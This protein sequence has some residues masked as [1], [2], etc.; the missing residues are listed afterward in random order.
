MTNEYL[1]FAT[2]ASANVLTQSDYAALPA[3]TSGF[4]AGV[5]KSPELNKVWRQS[6]FMASMLAQFI[7]DSSG[8]D[9]LDDGNLPGL[10][11]KLRRALGATATAPIGSMSN[12]RMSIPTNSA[13]ATFTADEV[14]VGTALGGRSYRLGNF[15]QT[16]NVATTGAGGMDTGTPPSSGWVGI[17]AIYNPST[18]A[19]ALL[20][21]N[22]T[23]AAAPPVYGGTNMPAGY[24]ASGL[25]S[26]WRI[27]GASLLFAGF[28]TGNTIINAGLQAL[29][30]TTV[31]ATLTP[32]DISL[33]VPRNAKTAIGS[34]NA[35]ATGAG[36]IGMAVSPSN[37]GFGT[38]TAQVQATG[39]S[40][41]LNQYNIPIITTQL[42]YYS[43]NVTGGSS[44]A[45]TLVVVGYT[46]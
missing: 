26:V 2:G 8:E 1:P 44:P 42:M 34:I 45:A 12:A 5:A 4:S 11:A 28:Q 23:N 40:Q 24:T 20:A 43:F 9:V 31:Q 21:T 22:A 7:A 36:L 39:V 46:F 41:I 16:I 38:Q 32:I 14:V 29:S 19:R 17:Y 6:S 37:P 13:T 18:G 27:T 25:V 35:M 15:S 30:V 33:A 10:E 3:R